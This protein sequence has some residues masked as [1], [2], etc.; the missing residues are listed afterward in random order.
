M[1]LRVDFCC[2]FKFFNDLKKI[3]MELIIDD[4]Q[5]EWIH[6][7][8]V[9]D[10]LSDTLNMPLFGNFA[11]RSEGL[12]YQCT[13]QRWIVISVTLYYTSDTV[14]TVSRGAVSVV[15]MRKKWITLDQ[16]H[17]VWNYSK[18]CPWIIITLTL[19]WQPMWETDKTANAAWL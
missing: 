17:C 19:K 16:A 12:D 3:Q 9:S 1:A 11:F 7:T 4:M 13:L 14:V 5:Q 2:G 18:I 10:L 15:G 6:H 8:S